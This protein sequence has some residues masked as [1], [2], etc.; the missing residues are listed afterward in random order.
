VPRV[1]R[2]QPVTEYCRI[3]DVQ[4]RPNV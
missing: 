1:E 4:C 2:A 3:F